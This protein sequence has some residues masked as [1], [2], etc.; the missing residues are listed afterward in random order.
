[1]LLRK[2]ENNIEIGIVRF[3]EIND[4]ISGNVTEFVNDGKRNTLYFLKSL[5][6]GRDRLYLDDVLVYIY[7]IKKQHQGLRIDTRAGLKALSYYIN[8]RASE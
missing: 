3:Y 1:M 4:K 8:N 6:H 5:S 2:D 7:S